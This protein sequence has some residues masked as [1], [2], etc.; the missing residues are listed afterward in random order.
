MQS[1]S[2]DGYT[3]TEKEK[4]RLVQAINSAGINVNGEEDILEIMKDYTVKIKEM[5]HRSELVFK[6]KYF[7]GRHFIVKR[8]G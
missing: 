8:E 2:I 7:N 4:F 3:L 6:N 5:P 1:I